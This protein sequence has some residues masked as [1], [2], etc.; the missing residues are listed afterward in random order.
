[1]WPLHHSIFLFLFKQKMQ[2]SFSVSSNSLFT[3]AYCGDCRCRTASPG[4]RKRKKRPEGRWKLLLLPT[5]QNPPGNLSYIVCI[6]CQQRCMFINI[7]FELV[8][9]F[10]MLVIEAFYKLKNVCPSLQITLLLQ[11]LR[12]LLLPMQIEYL[13]NH[14]RI[15]HTCHLRIHFTC[16]LSQK[17]NEPPEEVLD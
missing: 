10:W 5:S 9:F 11:L 1:M 13:P 8:V 14:V 12:F 4:R 3:F 17:V 2:K 7:L 16:H 15:L 6:L